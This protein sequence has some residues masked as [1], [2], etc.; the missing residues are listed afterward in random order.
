VPFDTATPTLY[1]APTSFK[2]HPSPRVRHVSC[3]RRNSMENPANKVSSA[4]RRCI[5]VAGMHRSGTSAITRVVNLLGADVAKELLPAKIDNQSG[6]WE[7][8]AVV[9]IHDQLLRTLGSSWDDPFPLPDRWIEAGATQQ[10]KRRLAEE[11]KRDFADSRLFVVKD[12]RISRLLPMWLEILD[13]LEIVPIVL[14]SVRNPLE[15]AASLEVRDRFS[16]AKSLVLYAHGCLETELESRGRQ[17]FFVR[18]EELLEDWR[19][20]AARLEKV[21]GTHSITPSAQRAAEIDRFLT[22]ELRHHHYS[23]ADLSGTRDIA[24][25]VVEIFDRMSD[26]ADGGD[27]TELRQ[28]FDRLHLILAEATRLYRGIVTAERAKAEEEMIRLR[29]DHYASE[30]HAA[31]E[32]SRL[33]AKVGRTEGEL[34][35]ACARRAESDVALARETARA[36]HLDGELAAMRDRATAA[37]KELDALKGEFVKHDAKI[38]ALD[39]ALSVRSEELDALKSALAKRDAKVTA[40]DDALFVRSEELDALKSAL[41]KRDAKVRSL[42]MMVSAL[43]ASTSWRITAPARSL[44]RSLGRLR[45]SVVGYAVTQAWRSL[46]THSLAP[47][48]DWRAVRTITRSGRFDRDWYIKNNPDVGELGIDPIRHYVA[49]GASEGRDPSPTFSTRGYL[50][51]NP[52]VSAAGVNPFGHFVRFGIKEHRWPAPQQSVGVDRESVSF[53]VR[54]RPAPDQAGAPTPWIT[55]KQFPLTGYLTVHPN[56]NEG[57]TSPLDVSVSVVIPTCN[58]GTEFYWLLRKLFA[59]KGLRHVEVIIVDSGSTDGTDTL[60]REMG[61]KLVPIGKSQFSHS[62]ARN[63]GAENASG[64][65]LLFTVQDAFPV[66]DHWL[67]GLVSCFLNSKATKTPLSAVSCAEFPRSD[68]EMLYNSLIDTHYKFLRCRDADRVGSL[69]GNDN[70]TLRTQGQLSDI[71]CLI[72]RPL[73]AQYRY[74]G[75]Y[76]EDLILGIR[77]IK[78][79]HKIGMLSSIKVVHSHN[80]PTSYY[81]RR[82]FVD[83]IFLAKI[84]PDFGIPATTSAVATL[85]AAFALRDARHNVV[86]SLD[87]APANAL[88]KVIGKLRALKLPVQ[89]ADLSGR[90]DFGYPPLGAWI[91]RVAERSGTAPRAM[92]SAEQQDAEQLR[93]MFI[94][95]LNALRTYVDSTYLALDETVASELND[96]VAKTLAMTIGSQLAFLFLKTPAAPADGSGDLIPELMSILLAG[97]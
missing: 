38:T 71:A 18:Y 16:L 3:N 97:I 5:I 27:E 63:L 32:N 47:L 90:G 10:A 58:A 60:A 75:N 81:V 20:F 15:I 74:N 8:L 28:T 35:A 26:V 67:Y 2:R 91:D 40:L 79:G 48:R 70:L 89:I 80:R 49:Y 45:L 56:L 7:S 55:K 92:T 83:V 13:E 73:F 19:P 86:A 31:D 61:C 78:D 62:Y 21:A 87:E 85:M 68:T 50:T 64:E 36:A 54:M 34:E 53:H 12:P 88:G 44:R 93:N 1:N 76:A 72:P 33:Q 77:L 43:Y 37:E 94:D 23:R 22:A 46:T 9:N 52:D 59:Q 57:S 66:G 41:A 14:V 6:F 17:R 96:A 30:A 51:Q 29:A 4:S 69:G 84:F 25:T 82:V 39:D 95:R 65:M 42:E 11:I 24:A